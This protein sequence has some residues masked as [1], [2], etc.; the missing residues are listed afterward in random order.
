MK[1]A[2]QIPYLRAPRILAKR[3]VV[4]AAGKACG[5]G[6]CDHFA[7][8]FVTNLSRECFSSRNVLRARRRRGLPD[9]LGTVI[10]GLGQGPGREREATRRAVTEAASDL[11]SAGRQ[12]EGPD[13]ILRVDVQRSVP[14][15]TRGPGVP[16]N[17]GPDRCHPLLYDRRQ[18]ER[19]PEAA[20]LPRD[21][22]P[23]AFHQAARTSPEATSSSC[24][25]LTGRADASV[26]VMS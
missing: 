15:E 2:L 10:G 26:A 8:L 16:R 3:A 21:C 1:K 4:I 23:D 7:Q 13:R 5:G 6:F 20:E 22:V 24:A 9:R 12:L 14:R 11:F 17:L 25:G 19:G 18:P